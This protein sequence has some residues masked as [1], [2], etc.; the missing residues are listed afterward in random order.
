MHG[1]DACAVED[2]L[3]TRGAW[4]ETMQGMI[5]LACETAFRMVGNST[6]SPMANEV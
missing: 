5:S 1:M 2:L 3:T 6:I 4:T